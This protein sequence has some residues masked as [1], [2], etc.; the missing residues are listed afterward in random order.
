[1]LHGI[2]AYFDEI[3]RF[4]RRLAAFGIGVS[5]LVVGTM[6]VLQRP[7]VAAALSDPK[8]FG[9]EGPEQFVERI[10]LEMQGE[11][12]QLGSNAVNVAPVSKRSGGGQ[13]EPAQE[14]MK[15]APVGPK[16]G[17]SSGDDEMT[18][19]A[20][21]R[22]LALAGPIVQSQD[23]VVETMVRPEYPEEARDQDIEGLVEL[24]ALVD[25][26]GSVVQVEIIGGSRQPLLEQAATT[27]V[28]KC[29]YRPYRIH[30]DIEPVWAYFR[31]TF[32]LY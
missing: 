28:L 8:R 13:R 2:D 22:A 12:E 3:T 14:G 4:Q 19:E 26:T 18:L 29:R 23:L 5:L 10:L 24:V 20:R 25:T 6:F 9:Y 32:R 15:P 17:Q 31:I 11:E 30:E 1:M 7:E 21:L 27:A 16:V